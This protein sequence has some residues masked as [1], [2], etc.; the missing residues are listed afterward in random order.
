[1]STEIYVIDST[2][3]FSDFYNHIQY[4]STTY[5]IIVSCFEKPVQ[6]VGVDK[7]QDTGYKSTEI[8]TLHL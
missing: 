7:K 3:C 8:M 1:M 5:F 6:T 4:E 2:L